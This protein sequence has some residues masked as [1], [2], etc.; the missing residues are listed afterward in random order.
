M[1]PTACCVQLA[2]TRSHSDRA[3]SHAVSGLTIYNNCTLQLVLS[4]Q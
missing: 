1:L 4:E 3:S 2:A